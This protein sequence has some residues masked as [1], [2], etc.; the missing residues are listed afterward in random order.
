MNQKAIKD[1]LQDFSASESTKNDAPKDS[2]PLT[3]WLP[4]EVKGRYDQLQASSRRR[5]GKKVREILEALIT[6]AESRTA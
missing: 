3:I 4:S 6:A 5:F 2:R 1:I